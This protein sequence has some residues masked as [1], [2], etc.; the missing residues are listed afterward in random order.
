MYLGGMCVHSQNS[1]DTEMHHFLE[2]AR[3]TYKKSVQ[4]LTYSGV[5]NTAAEARN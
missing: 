5:E 4:V 1:G 3:S 2:K